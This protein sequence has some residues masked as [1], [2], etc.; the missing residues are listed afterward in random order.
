MATYDGPGTRQSACPMCVPE[1]APPTMARGLGGW[2]RASGAPT[3]LRTP[4]V[5]VCPFCNGT[6]ENPPPVGDL[7]RGGGVL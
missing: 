3:R 2:Y 1:T 5:V 6:G 4:D 7:P